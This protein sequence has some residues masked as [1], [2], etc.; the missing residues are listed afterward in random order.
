VRFRVERS[1]LVVMRA[2]RA[3]A[4]GTCS[5]SPVVER[6]P[7]AYGKSNCRTMRFGDFCRSF[8]PERTFAARRSVSGIQQG[9]TKSGA[10]ISGDM[11]LKWK[12]IWSQVAAALR[13]PFRQKGPTSARTAIR[14][15]LMRVLKMVVDVRFPRR[16][17]ALPLACGVF[18]RTIRCP[19]NLWRDRYL[20]ESLEVLESNSSNPRLHFARRRLI[21]SLLAAHNHRIRLDRNHHTGH[22]PGDKLPVTR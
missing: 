20:A 4:Q 9:E 15:G 5:R 13:S 12:R 6:R 14:H 22:N 19:D 21:E 3:E 10:V 2:I 16:A 8:L 1:G 11:I 7:A 17:D 18:M